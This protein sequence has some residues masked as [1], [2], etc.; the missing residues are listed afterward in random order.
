VKIV[1]TFPEDSHAPIIYPAAVTKDSKAAD[2]R[3]FLDYLKSTKARPSFEK[4]GF[5]VLAKSASA[6]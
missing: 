4:Q 2:A 3:P 1:G 6:T 5:T